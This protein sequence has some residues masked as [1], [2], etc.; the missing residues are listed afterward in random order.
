MKKAK[1][2]NAKT[3]QRKP[4]KLE[5]TL[6]LDITTAYSIHEIRNSKVKITKFFI[7]RLSLYFENIL[8]ILD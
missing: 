8:S 1:A 6:S 7:T 5:R 4:K 3:T 2:I